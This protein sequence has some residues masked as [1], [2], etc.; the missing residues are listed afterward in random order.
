MKTYLIVLIAI[1]MLCT[2]TTSAQNVGIG[3]TSPLVKL[4]VAGR[5]RLQH[6]A[7]QTA[8]IFFDGTSEPQRSFIGTINNDHVGIFGAGTGWKFAFNVNNGNVGIGATDPTTTLDVNGGFRLRG[9]FPA[10][11]HVLTSVDASG[12]ADWQAPVAFKVSGLLNGASQNIGNYSWTKVMFNSSLNYNLGLNFQPLLS[13]F[14]IAEKGVYS[15]TFQLTYDLNYYLNENTAR[16]RLN[17]N[18][19]ISTVNDFNH[20]YKGVDDNGEFSYTNSSIQSSYEGNFEAGDIV[21]LE[22]HINGPIDHNQ[23]AKTSVNLWSNYCWF[24]GHL[25]ARF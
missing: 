5:L 21:W 23:V 24:A 10:K 14:L 7:G 1:T 18:G 4:D 9:T 22:A 11:G 2:K 20:L 6:N 12:N 16:L 3:T 19:N 17:R 15:F 8:G 13:Q 25:V